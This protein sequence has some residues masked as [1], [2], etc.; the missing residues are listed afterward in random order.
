MISENTPTLETP[1]LILRKL[2][3][4]ASDMNAM[5]AILSDEVISK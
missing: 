1:R 5:F 4:S 2:T 3:R